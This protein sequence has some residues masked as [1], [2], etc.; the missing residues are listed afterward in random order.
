MKINNAMQPSNNFDLSDKSNCNNIE[1]FKSILHT[2]DNSNK[3][4]KD[5]LSTLTS[6]ELYKIQKANN[7]AS[8]INVSNLSQEG[9]ENLFNRPVDGRELVDLN[10]DGIVEVGEAKSFVFPPP[11]APES[12]KEAWEEATADLTL[13]EKSLIKFKFLTRQLEANSF[14][15]AN[16]NIKILSPGDSGW[17]N[18]FGSTE[19]D[20]ISLLKE[21]I[22]R[23]DNPLAPRNEQ[24]QQNDQLARDVFSDMIDIINS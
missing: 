3:S 17:V 24:E 6:T 1:D 23:I 16:G 12:V 10:N 7:L 22:D 18:I 2:R 21:L 15:D 9:A 4:A 11:N 14:E 13:R 5:F 19:D 20:Y 8:P